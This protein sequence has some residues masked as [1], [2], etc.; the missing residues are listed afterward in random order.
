MPG[1]VRDAQLACLFSILWSIV[2]SCQSYSQPTGADLERAKTRVVN[3]QKL[4]DYLFE[5][6][7]E[8]KC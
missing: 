5:S 3:G 4:I 1:T 2:M 7:I 8:K 6:E